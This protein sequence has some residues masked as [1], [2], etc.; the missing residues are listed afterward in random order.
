MSLVKSWEIDLKDPKITEEKFSTL[1]RLSRVEISKRIK[2][3]ASREN[4]TPQEVIEKYFTEAQQKL[5]E[6]KDVFL[7]DIQ[8][9]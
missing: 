1:L 2:S 9:S 3:L 5:F 4:I 8:P 7:K 6:S